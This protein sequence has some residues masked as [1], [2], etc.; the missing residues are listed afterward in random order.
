MLTII[1]ACSNNQNN[2]DPDANQINNLYQDLKQTYIAY[3]CSLQNKQDSIPN[4][5]ALDNALRKTYAKYPADLDT[6]L[7]QAQN[8][9]LWQLTQKY[10]KIKE[11]ITQTIPIPADTLPLNEKNQEI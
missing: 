1:T 9:T 2:T 3:T 6:K 5:D 8:D 4:L 11:K 7:S 10:N